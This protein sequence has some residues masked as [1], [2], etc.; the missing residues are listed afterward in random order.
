M[1][2]NPSKI[3]RRN[4]REPAFERRLLILEL[5]SVRRFATVQ[6]LADRFGV[7]KRTIQ[8]DLDYLSS[9]IP[10]YSIRGKGGGFHVL[11]G[12]KKNHQ[13]LTNDQEDLL[14]RLLPTL[15]HVDQM[16]IQEIISAFSFHQ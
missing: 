3:E 16:I 11:E 13:Y 12:W 8:Y 2:Y 15:S 6:E 10:V 4:R 7:C 1:V 5:L 9:F 14:L